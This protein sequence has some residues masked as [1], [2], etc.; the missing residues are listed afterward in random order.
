MYLNLGKTNIKYKSGYKDDFIILSEVVNS[1]LSYENPILIRTKDE[2]DIWFGKNFDSRDYFDELL[3]QNVTLYLYK[4]VSNE[5][6]EY[7]EENYIDLDLYY[8]Y[9]EIYHSI[10]NLPETGL[11]EYRYYVENLPRTSHFYTFGYDE[12]SQEYIWLDTVSDDLSGYT[13][14]SNIYNSIYDLPTIG[15]IGVIYQVSEVPEYKHWYIWNSNTEKWENTSDYNTY[16]QYYKKFSTSSNLFSTNKFKYYTIKENKWYTWEDDSWTETNNETIMSF[17]IHF[18]SKESLPETGDN[19][20]YYVL[21]DSNWY[22]WNEFDES[23]LSEDLFPQNID[24]LSS[25]INNR[26]TLLISKID[27]NN[28]NIP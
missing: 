15:Q 27:E 3:K 2:L 6:A 7:S 13:L 12:V 21:E 17:P 24:N 14:D 25:S 16:A 9:P 8:P 22:I 19:Y 1:Q 5:L 11:S 20:K 10:D 4:P 23:W 18:D 26:D 28:Q